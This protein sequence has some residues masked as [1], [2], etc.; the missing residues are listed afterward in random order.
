MIDNKNFYPTP[1]KLI[2]KMWS[3]IKNKSR[4]TR[5][6]EPSAG[7][8]NIVKYII[9]KEYTT[10][11]KD[12]YSISCI[13]IDTELQKTLRGSNYR[14]IDSNFLSYSGADRFDIIIAN[15]P[16]DE[17]DAHLMKA[18]DIMYSGEIVFLLNA[19]TIKNPYS[20]QRKLL[21]QRLEELNAEIE[22]IQNAF[23]DAER[24]TGVEVA[25]VYI[26]IKRNIEDD[27]FK[28]CNDKATDVNVHIEQDSD[29]VS[30]SNIESRVELYNDTLRI[31]LT[32]I[33]EY[34]KNYNKINKYITLNAINENKESYRD[35]DSLN[36]IVNEARN[37]FVQTL[38]KD[39]WKSLLTLEEVYSRMTQK[40]IE[41]FNFK[42]E[43][44]SY[45]DF[46]ASNIRAFLLNIIG[47]YE[48]TMIEAV[49][50]I[51][52][53]FT[54]K[55]SYNEEC[56]KNIHYFT[57]W[58]TN[59]A[60]YVNKKVVLPMWGSF[61]HP[62]MGWSGWQLCCS[63]ERKLDDIDKVM[64]YFDASNEY[65]S[66]GT[67]IKEAFEKDQTRG[68][69]STYFEISVFKKR[70]IHLIFRDDNIRR[71]FNVIACKYKKWLS[72]DYGKK[73]YSTMSKEEQEVVNEFEGKSSYEKNLDQIGFATKNSS[74]QLM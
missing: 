25:L 71:R 15:P 74:L 39:Y 42:I 23:I 63:V 21:V 29:I 22:Y 8:G 55:H 45:M 32:T 1:D 30:G 46:T 68:I 36:T 64:N 24:K 33:W 5:I 59:K 6:L 11:Y 49:A 66:I 38:R 3:K 13:E 65:V 4:G 70:T 9:D 48:N 44:Y 56:Q 54:E 7:K 61:G 51:F 14:V 16:F 10:W 28:D 35:K 26:E 72:Q 2:S 17:G 19:E 50:E 40:K 73:K 47:N 69:L 34:Y 62:F 52:E 43:E 12:F 67:A 53:L 31:G 20:N 58:C 60:F 27:L 37:N 57:G 18:I 41:D